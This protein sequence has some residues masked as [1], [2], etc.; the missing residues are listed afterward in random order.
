MH[1]IEVHLED[2]PWALQAQPGLSSPSESQTSRPHSSQALEESVNY[3][4][5]L[6]IFMCFTQL[7]KKVF[8]QSERDNISLVLIVC[9]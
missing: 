2:L 4:Y 1:R 9:S 8:F 5:V 7:S 3:V 6:V